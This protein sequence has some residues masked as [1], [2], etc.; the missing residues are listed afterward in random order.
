MGTATSAEE[1]AKLLGMA[2]T[3]ASVTA[4]HFSL[5]QTSSA[6]QEKFWG[7]L[8]RKYGPTAAKLAGHAIKSYMGLAQTSTTAV[9]KEKWLGMALGA[10]HLGWNVYKHFS[11]IETSTTAEERWGWMK[12]FKKYA[13]IAIN[14]AKHAYKAYNSL[15]QTSSTAVQKEKWLG[16]ALKAAHMGYNL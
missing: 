9:E 15:A 8:L 4:R 3:A 11:L 1:K 10:A 14:L 2:L 12:A 13:P 6:A 5:A 16:M 7:S